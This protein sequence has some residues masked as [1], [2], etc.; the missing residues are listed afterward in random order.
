MASDQLKAFL[1][2]VDRKASHSS[3][4][5]NGLH[6]EPVT[7]RANPRALHAEQVTVPFNPRALDP[8]KFSFGRQRRAAIQLTKYNAAR[9]QLPKHEFERLVSKGY[10]EI[11]EAQSSI[12]HDV[13]GFLRACKSGDTKDSLHAR[14]DY[15]FNIVAAVSHMPVQRNKVLDGGLTAKSPSVIVEQPPCVTAEEVDRQGKLYTAERKILSKTAWIPQYS[16]LPFLIGIAIAGDVFLL[17]TYTAQ[18]KG[19]HVEL[20]ISNV[21]DR[22]RCL[23]AAI[24]VGRY[25]KYIAQERLLP[26]LE[27]EFNRPWV[28][29]RRRLVISWKEVDKTYCGMERADRRRLRAFYGECNDVPYLERAK[30]VE[31]EAGCLRVLLTPVGMQRLPN[32]VE[33]AKTGRVAAS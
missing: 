15:F 18:G 28:T 2:D 11:S 1:R 14:D 8:K 10:I 23:R 17:F 31:E 27:F 7:V 32:D 9:T 13:V 33:E 5:P 4:K 19:Q 16:R 22:A 29:D 25:L 6:A 30:S 3:G 20:D 26:K 24:N 21:E 12:A